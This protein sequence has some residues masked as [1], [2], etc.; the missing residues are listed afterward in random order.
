MARATARRRK[1]FFLI[2]WL[3]YHTSRSC[4]K[5]YV[6]P[7][8]ELLLLRA[9]KSLTETYG[10]KSWELKKS[11]YPTSNAC[12]G[13]AAFDEQLRFTRGGQ[14]ALAQAF[15]KDN[16]VNRVRKTFA[17]WLSTTPSSY[18]GSTTASSVQITSS[19]TS[20]GAASGTL[21]LGQQF[22]SAADQ[23]TD[24]QGPPLLRI[25]CPRVIQIRETK[26]RRTCPNI[27]ALA[28]VCGRGFSKVA[29]SV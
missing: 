12:S 5:T 11:G 13:L 28:S 21:R 15:Q 1:S 20:D 6:F 23:R 26:L 8:Q 22:R 24:H 14:L 4:P 29:K 27:R 19:I 3:T 17:T 25:Q 18:A 10:R 7:D 9:W 16:D 2:H